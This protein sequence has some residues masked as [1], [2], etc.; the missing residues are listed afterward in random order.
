V[1][2]TT[3]WTVLV[4]FWRTILATFFAI[5]FNTMNEHKELANS[6]GRDLMKAIL[7]NE[8]GG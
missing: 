2:I 3:V 6:E 1:K 7:Q 4:N 8:F 5:N